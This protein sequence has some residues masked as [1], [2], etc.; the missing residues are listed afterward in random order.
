MT[1]ATI[2]RHVPVTPEKAFAAWTDPETMGS[3][4]TANPD[5]PVV[6]VSIDPRPG[7]AFRVS[8]QPPGQTPLVEEGTFDVFDPPHR[9]EYLE[10][11]RSGQQTVHGPAPTTVTFKALGGGTEVR[12]DSTV[13]PGEDKAGRERGWGNSLDLF[14]A[15]LVS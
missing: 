2:V 14:V 5:W 7:G 9:I 13:L 6:E 11:V 10:H 12:V 3:F 8:F 15:V 1:V 4:W